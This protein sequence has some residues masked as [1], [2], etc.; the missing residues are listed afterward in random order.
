MTNE[1]NNITEA[2]RKALGALPTRGFAKSMK[3]RHPVNL[4]VFTQVDLTRL[5]P[6]KLNNGAN[7]I[8]P[9]YVNP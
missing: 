4:R 5:K 3:T 2:E 6:P 8:S 7:I 9:R 1:Y